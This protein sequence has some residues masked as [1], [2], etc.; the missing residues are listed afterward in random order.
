MQCFYVEETAADKVDM[1]GIRVCMPMT[2]SCSGCDD[3][4]LLQIYVHRKRFDYSKQMRVLTGWSG[5]LLAIILD[6]Y[7]PGTRWHRD[8]AW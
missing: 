6:K 1:L 8:R 3:V 4:I 5:W 2:I 7:N